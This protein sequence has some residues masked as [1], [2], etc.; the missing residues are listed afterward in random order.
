M[1]FSC[2]TCGKDSGYSKRG[3][4]VILEWKQ[5][6]RQTRTYVCERCDAENRLDLPDDKWTLIDI[7]QASKL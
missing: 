3:M 6:N 5:F 7:S 4:D 1:Q 2:G